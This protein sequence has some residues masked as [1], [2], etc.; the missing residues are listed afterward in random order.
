MKIWDY[1]IPEDWKPETESQLLW[2]LERKINYDDWK[3]LKKAWIKKYF[4]T[5]KDRLDPGKAAMLEFY[6]RHND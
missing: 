5:L 4:P 1:N 2:H 6:L 3:G